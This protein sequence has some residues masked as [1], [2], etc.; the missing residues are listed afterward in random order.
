MR[1]AEVAVLQELVDVV[2]GAPLRRSDREHFLQTLG[3]GLPGIATTGS[4][5]AGNSSSA[6]V[7]LRD[8]EKARSAAKMRILR[9]IGE[10][11]YDMPLPPK[12]TEQVDVRGYVYF[13][14]ALRTEAVWEHPLRSDFKET[15]D[16]ASGLIDGAGLAEAAAS[17]RD[18]LKEV[19]DRAAHQL[20]D[21]T[22]PH[23][24]EDGGDEFF[25]NT[26]TD[27]SSWES[28][29]EAWQYELHARYWLLVQLLE[30]MHKWQT[31][32]Q[33]LYDATPRPCMEP[34][35]AYGA[36]RRQGFGTQDK[37]SSIAGS[38]GQS[39]ASKFERTMSES[40]LS[41]EVR[42]HATEIAESLVSSTPS[43]CPGGIGS[44]DSFRAG[45][46]SGPT[47]KPPPPRR[48]PPPM[49]HL[50]APPRIS[51]LLPLTVLHAGAG[52]A[53][54][55][56][57]RIA[58]SPAV[59]NPSAPSGELPPPP[60]PPD[61]P[62]A[63]QVVRRGATSQSS[64][65]PPPAQVAVGAKTDNPEP[66]KDTPSTNVARDATAPTVGATSPPTGMPPSGKVEGQSQPSR[67]PGEQC[68][69]NSSTNGSWSGEV[70]PRQ[71]PR[72]SS[73]I[74]AAM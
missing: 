31:P 54:G 26:A 59:E 8:R 60:P 7:A 56:P 10:A 53:G 13:S 71:R 16:F 34:A 36:A 62:V 67:Q 33:S 63:G 4:T 65:P 27:E 6:S 14:N 40:G 22:G 37:P 17:V 9:C 35:E 32:H 1:S 73:M 74:C 5:S 72:S 24:P 51:D 46:K 70:Q 68:Q 49:R 25:Y 69:S 28:P 66:P 20:K 19:Q 44:S 11:A 18:H 21:W 29:L 15:I 30:Q 48:P 58:L 2:P 23:C 57:G 45:S 42:S 38:F 3:L 52:G 55:S 47:R 50:A 61:T 41:A 43:F 64:M 39:A 12:W